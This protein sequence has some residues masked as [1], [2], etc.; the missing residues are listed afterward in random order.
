MPSN[1][2][3]YTGKRCGSSCEQFV[4]NTKDKPNVR[5]IGQN[6]A[7][8]ID[9]SNLLRKTLPSG[10]LVLKYASTKSLRI[11]QRPIDPVGIPPDVYFDVSGNKKKNRKTIM[12]IKQQIERGLL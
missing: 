3:I 5:S 7:G 10:E 11:P 8:G 4:L 9:F 2:L 1:V 6:T 12:A